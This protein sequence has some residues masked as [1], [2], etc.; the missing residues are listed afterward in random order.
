MRILFVGLV[1]PYP[2]LN[3]HRLRT[4]AILRALAQDGHQ[5]TLLSFA[6]PGEEVAEG[7]PLIELCQSIELMAPPRPNGGRGSAYVGRAQSLLSPL[8]HGVWRFRSAG[9]KKRIEG[10]L[11]RECFDAV[12]C[13]GVYNMV[14]LP[15]SL[16]VPVLLNKDDVAHVLVRRH[17]ELERNAAR[18]FYA[19]LE[20]QKLRRWEEQ[21]GQRCTAIWACSE[22]D[23]KQLQA[24]CPGVPIVVVPN[25]VDTDHYVPAREEDPLII[26]YQGGMD[27][28][29]NRDAVEFFVSQILPKLRRLVPGAKFV[30]AGRNPSEEFR[31]RFAGIPGVEFTGTL[32]DMRAEMAKAAVCV[33]PLRVASGTRLKILEAAAMAKP[34]VSTGVGAEGLEFVNRREIVL[35]DEPQ[36]FARE[37][38]DLLTDASRRQALGQ[39]ARRRVEQQYSFPVLRT[40]VRHALA[41][42]GTSRWR[43]GKQPQPILSADEGPR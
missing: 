27:W 9:F 13:D 30:V 20:Y 3:G 19:W 38:A 23:Q 37:V 15:E 6:D 25:V 21:A 10:A 17:L 2:P 29:P 35:A 14:N 24:L 16:A 42:L 40:A 1:I 11:A 34:V 12:L 32:P 28:H 33:V 39:A 18:R 5:V 41:E 7:N 43:S 8:P 22:C 36:T 4:W 31:R 26:L